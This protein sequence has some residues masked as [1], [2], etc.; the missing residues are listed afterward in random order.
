MAPR[1]LIVD[2]HQI[3]RQGVRTLLEEFRPAWEICGEAANANEALQALAN[4]K[5][6]L[7]V[8]DI[9]MPG[10]SGLEVASEIRRLGLPCQILIF[11][12]HHSE[13][14]GSDVRAAGAQGYVLKSQA[15]QDLVLAIERILG[16]GTFY[17]EEDEGG[18]GSDPKPNRN[19][20]FCRRLAFAGV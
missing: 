8:L 18:D 16:G 14:L 7:M 11:T 9:T 5:P 17:G 1:I 15:A 20:F 13:R 4:L 6:D 2:D 12:M 3:V 19:L 10:Q